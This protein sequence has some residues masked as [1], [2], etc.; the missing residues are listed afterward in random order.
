MVQLNFCEARKGVMFE[1]PMRRPHPLTANLLGRT[2]ARRVPASSHPATRD[3]AKTYVLQ[4]LLTSP[5]RRAFLAKRLLADVS[6]WRKTTNRQHSN[7][8]GNALFSQA[9]AGVL[10][11]NKSLFYLLFTAVQS[12]RLGRRRV[13]SCGAIESRAAGLLF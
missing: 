7:F 3:A 4:E 5:W 12:L 11:I 8:N 13:A 9:G 1:F 2:E 6:I 10:W